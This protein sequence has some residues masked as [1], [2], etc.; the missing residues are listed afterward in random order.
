MSHQTISSN[1][2]VCAAWLYP[3]PKKELLDGIEK[4]VMPDKLSGFS[5]MESYGV[6]SILID[7]YDFPLNPLGSK[8]SLYAGI[9]FARAIRVIL[10]K[11][12]YDV[13][14]SVGES[15]MLFFVL[16]RQIFHVKL[17]PL[18]VWDPALTTEWKLRYRILKYILPRLN[19]I[20][21]IGQNQVDFVEQ[22]FNCGDKCEVIPHWIDCDF[23]DPNKASYLDN[24][25]PYILTV[26]NDA[27]RD[28]STLQ[29][30]VELVEIKTIFKTSLVQENNDPNVLINKE[31]LSFI[32]LRDLYA[33]AKFVVVPLHN[34]IH[35][36]GIN[37]IQEAMAMGLPT[38]VSRSD[39]IMD[40][41]VD[42]ITSIIVEPGDVQQLVNAINTLNT[43]TT[44][45]KEMGENARKFVKNKFDSPL[46]AERLAKTFN[47]AVKSMNGT[48]D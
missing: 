19:K 13:I 20:L 28:Y 41:V 1:S 25:E 14:F 46:L 39:G 38:I 31:F 12:K 33:N 15:S 7:P 34:T 18:I 6:D 11:T 44:L 23:F 24:N 37:G 17:P 21:V 47:S 16:F 32:E 30:A 26:G 35:A 36:G 5:F 29:K 27:G 4:G 2:R 9:D 40:H 43:N 3:K 48:F 45:A 42:G 22:H 8:H 10:N